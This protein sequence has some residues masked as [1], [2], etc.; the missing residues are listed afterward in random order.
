MKPEW[1]FVWSGLLFG[2]AAAAPP[3]TA[4]P[5][6]GVP[7]PQQ[8]AQA[9]AQD[10]GASLKAALTAQL[11]QGDTTAAIAFC[12]DEA[13]KIAARIAAAHGVRLG[14]VPVAGRQRSPANSPEPWQAQGL[15]RF[16]ARAAAGTPPGELVEVTDSGLPAGVSLR[17]MRGI[18]VEPMCLA[19]HGKALEPATRA[20]LQRLYPTDSAT[21]FAAGDLRGA[22]WVEVPAGRGPGTAP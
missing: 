19:C 21:G 9:A 3:P 10:F 2:T 13:P 18:A 8:R 20:A 1:M 5:E 22:L 7:T 14:R 11:A 4:S 16:Q 12:R 17:W 15:A 6:A